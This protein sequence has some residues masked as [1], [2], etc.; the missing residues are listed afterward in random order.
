[1]NASEHEIELSQEGTSEREKSDVYGV[2]RHIICSH[3]HVFI[4][5]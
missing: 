4:E 3:I 5:I 1:M 2:R